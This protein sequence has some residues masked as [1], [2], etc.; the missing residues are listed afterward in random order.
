MQQHTRRCNTKKISAL[1]IPVPDDIAYCTSHTTV[2][3]S[4]RKICEAIVR[5]LAQD[6]VTLMLPSSRYVNHKVP[7]QVTQVLFR[8][9]HL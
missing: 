7:P 3:E 5:G 8:L 6:E 1:E 4:I 9:T 2:H